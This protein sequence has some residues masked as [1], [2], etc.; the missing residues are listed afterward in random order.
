MIENS[1]QI[2]ENGEEDALWRMFSDQLRTARLTRNPSYLNEVLLEEAKNL[3][4]SPLA[5]VLRL[6]AADS[7]VIEKRY[8]DANTLYEHVVENYYNARFVGAEVVDGALKQSAVCHERLGETDQSIEIYNRLAE[9]HE[10]DNAW[11][12]FHIG[13]VSENSGDVDAA[14]AAYS[15][16]AGATDTLN[17]NGF[18]IPDLAER[19]AER[20]KNPSKGFYDHPQEVA[21][22]LAEALRRKDMAA[23]RRLASTTHF[24]VGVAGG[25]GYFADRDLILDRIATDLKL[26]ERYVDPIDLQGEGGKR[27]LDTR[28][29]SGEWLY[30]SV[31]F[32]IT[33]SPQGW[34]WSGIVLSQPTL[35]WGKEWEPDVKEKNQPLPFDLVAPWPRY[36]SFKAGGLKQY[37]AV[38][39]ALLAL[40]GPFKGFAT[41][42]KSFN[43]CGFGPRGFYYNF[44]PTHQGRDAFAIDFTRYVFGVPYY[45]A[46]RGTD[47]L[48]VRSGVVSNV[49]ERYITGNPYHDNHVYIQHEHKGT[50]RYESRYLHLTGPNRIRVSRHQYVDSGDILG[51]MDDT[52][53]SRLH[54]LHFSIHDID[55]GRAGVRPTPMAGERLMDQDGGKCIE[56]S[57]RPYRGWSFSEKNPPPLEP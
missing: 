32:L 33:R 16:A 26:G 41:L 11:A 42:L 28:G 57:T 53:N 3:G 36:R 45:N 21:N 24:S 14:I 47:I 37:I 23:L 1:S 51:Q 12:L 25:C 39:A 43:P 52:G 55:N 22:S 5:A 20:L 19:A 50:M 13:R 31:Y 30:D 46:S 9:K 54:H 48:A 27:Y 4:D 56:S 34:D 49:E 35:N 2:L 18:P 17:Q 40:P 29:W 7:L 15:K 6:W 10:P 38:Q 44:G 8:N